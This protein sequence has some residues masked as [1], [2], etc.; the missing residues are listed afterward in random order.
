MKTWYSFTTILGLLLVC[1][2][3][4]IAQ[5]ENFAEQALGDSD[6]NETPTTFTITD[7][8]ED[9]A[10]FDFC[11][12]EGIETNL[13]D[14][15]SAG[16]EN[17]MPII[18]CPPEMFVTTDPGRCDV[19]LTVPPPTISGGCP[20]YTFFNTFNG[21]PDASDT[22]N[23]G[24]TSVLFAVTDVCGNSSSC[25]LLINLSDDEDPV[26]ECK[27]TTIQLN[28]NGSYDITESDVY[29]GGT[30]NCFN[31]SYVG[32]SPSKVNCSDAGST[33]FVTVT[34]DDNRGNTG[35]CVA[36]VT[37]EDD[38]VDAVTF[39]TPPLDLCESEG[40]INGISGGSPAGGVYSGPGVTDDGNGQ[41]YS[42]NTNVA[43]PGTHILTY[44]LGNCGSASDVIT[45]I[46]KP[47]ITC[48]DEI[49]V[50]TDPGRC[51]VDLT[52][53]PPIITG[54]C[55]P[56]S[57]SNTFNFTSDASDT[58][59]IGQTSVLFV[60]FDDSNNSASCQL[61]INLSDNEDPNP[62]CATTTVDLG[63]D[64]MYVFDG[65]EVLLE[66]SSDNCFQVNFESAS[67]AQVTCD[68]LGST[69]TV[70][71]TVNDGRGNTNTCDATVT[72][73]DPNSYCCDGPDAVCNDFTLVLDGDGKGSISVTDIAAASS[74]DCG[75]TSDMLSKTNFDCDDLG[76]GNVV[77]YTITDINNDSDNCTS[78]ITVQDNSAPM[79]ECKTTTVILDNDGNYDLTEAD[80]FNGGTDNCGIVNFQSMSPMSVNCDDV[81]N[82][83]SITVTANDGNGNTANCIALVTPVDNTKPMATCNDFTVELDANGQYN[84][85]Q[86]E[87]YAGGTDNCGTVNFESFSPMMVDCDDA[88]S[89][90][91]VT[92]MVNDGNGNSGMCTANVSVIDVIAPTPICKTSTVQLD[93]NGKYTLLPDDVYAGGTDNCGDIYFKEMSVHEVDCSQAETTITVVVTASDNSGNPSTCEAF[94]TV[95]DSID[96]VVACF[97][98][99]VSFNGQ[100]EITLS[101][102]QLYNAAGSSD[103]C[104]TVN[105]VSPTS[106]QIITCDQLGS[107]VP[108][109]VTINDGNGNTASCTAN[110]TVDG[111]PCDWVN[112]QGIG[113]TDQT[114]VDY[115]V[116]TETFSITSDDCTP[117][118]PY[119]WDNTTFVKQEL[120]GDGYIEAFIENIDGNGF[121]GV[122]MRNSLVIGAKKIALGTNTI[123]K[124][125]RELRAIDNYPAWPMELISFDKFW[126][127]IERNGMVFQASASVDGLTYIPYMTQSILMDDCIEVGLYTY[128]LVQGET[129]TSDFSEVT[130]GQAG[131]TLQELGGMNAAELGQSQVAPL[132]INV[133][134]NPATDEINLDLNAF[135]DQNANIQLYNNVGNLVLNQRIGAV[136][137]RL[138]TIPVNQLDAGVYYLSLV[139]DG[140]RIIKRMIIAKQ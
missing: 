136:Q 91:E 70:E 72:V 56:I 49:F 114:D 67:P 113:C 32:A 86:A 61:L 52:V 26:P 83:V 63:P 6:C 73:T 127:K 11:N 116:S 3:T 44:T 23:I 76:N 137:S 27:N 51:D 130:I 88:Q 106:N 20:S 139:V 24:Q 112:T 34:V 68:D 125:R 123:N 99:T 13:N 29:V 119:I 64:E 28:A 85:T 103:N 39:T 132:D 65:D 77:T 95:D 104:G 80:V 92:V 37:V 57:V 81:G 126:L 55:L 93:A 129:V 87:V 124:L 46:P 78:T 1:W 47:A 17:N 101:P 109:T 89:V 12:T 110:I 118:S 90:V 122:M 30:D 102:S 71:V 22:Y 18:I 36:E 19:D 111:L 131:G 42:F 94:I 79:P 58:Y 31:V 135:M 98:Q 74:T 115:D 38:N 66:E 43:G 16:D 25:Q 21:T 82:S 107:V 14:G 45:I 9:S 4:S 97:D 35:T 62:I 15:S 33:V 84:L 128:S 75:F 2:S 96:P 41:T 7:N 120:C 53:P 117:V 48:P 133:F 8:N 5:S 138:H 105:L 121:A 54:G 100:A 40:Q 59:N 134:P 140:Q 10:T 108:V 50:T 60:V 69:I